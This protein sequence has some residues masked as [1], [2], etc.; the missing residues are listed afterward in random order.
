M[1][2]MQKRTYTKLMLSIIIISLLITPIVP[3]SAKRYK[4]NDKITEH[5]LAYNVIRFEEK[6]PLTLDGSAYG[7]E[8][9]EGAY[10]TV[11]VYGIDVGPGVIL[12]D[13]GDESMA[14]DLYKSVR[15]AFKKPVLAVY[16]T[17]GHADH[18]GGG[19]YFQKKHVPIFASVYEFELIE[20][21]AS[22]PYYESPEMFLYTG[23]TPDFTYEELPLWCGFDYEY[24]PGHTMGHLV[25]SYENWHNSYVFTGDVIIEQPT[26]DPLDFTFTTSWF[27]ALTLYQLTP[28]YDC[29]ADW[30]VTLTDMYTL[31]PNYEIVCPGH[32][33]EYSSDDAAGYIWFTSY[34]LGEFSDPPS[35]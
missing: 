32:G 22:S 17:H 3:A 19:S 2:I 34:V 5:Q 26:T 24:A 23:Y 30:Q 35:I 33:S 18:A 21:G 25:L 31:M 1:R 14:K 27:T 16:L 20:D 10:Y 11:N 12:I 13:C 4:K 7:I 9:P 6:I 28:I 15:K 29:I 8:I